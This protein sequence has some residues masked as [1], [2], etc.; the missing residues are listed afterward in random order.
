MLLQIILRYTRKLTAFEIREIEILKQMYS[1]V[2]LIS[3]DNKTTNID[4]EIGF[5]SSK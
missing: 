2:L 3:W 4:A 1:I 5:C